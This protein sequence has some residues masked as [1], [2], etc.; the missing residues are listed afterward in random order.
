MFFYKKLYQNPNKYRLVRFQFFFIS[1]SSP[2]LISNIFLKE[3]LLTK[4]KKILIK[5]S[6]LLMMWFYWLTF[7]Q[8]HKNEKNQLKFFFLPIKKKIFTATK[9]PMAHKT[10]SKE[11]YEK[12]IFKIKIH[13]KNFLDEDNILSSANTALL[14]ALITKKNFPIF[15]TNVFFLKNYLIFFFFSDVR[16]FNFYN[17]LNI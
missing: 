1:L 13:F 14:A 6:Y 2:F 11:Q 3:Q 10:R 7:I 17:F 12:K 15:E 4:E 9:A 16:Y 8:T 5:Q